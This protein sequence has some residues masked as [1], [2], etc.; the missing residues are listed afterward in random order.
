MG[1]RVEVVKCWQ[2]RAGHGRGWITKTPDFIQCAEARLSKE[3]AEYLDGL[4]FP[5]EVANLL[6]RPVTAAGVEARAAAATEVA[7]A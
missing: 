5:F 7:H 4:R 3:L 1:G 2:R 6:P